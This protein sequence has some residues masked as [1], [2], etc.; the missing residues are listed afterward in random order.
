MG[1]EELIAY[2][3]NISKVPRMESAA[4]VAKVGRVCAAALLSG[5]VPE[6]DPEC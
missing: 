2:G 3:G 1:I 4:Q 5:T 6:G